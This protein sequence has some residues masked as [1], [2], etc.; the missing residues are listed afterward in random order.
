MDDINHEKTLAALER[1]ESE[2]ARRL[3]EKID[4]GEVVAREVRVVV[5][6]DEG[7][8]AAMT[9]AL[10]GN[11]ATAGI[12]DEFLYIVTNIPPKEHWKEQESSPPAAEAS[13]SSVGPCCPP[14]EEPAGS[15]GVSSP[16]PPSQPTYVRVIISNGE[17][18]DCGRI[19]EGKYIVEDG[20]VI[21]RDSNGKFITSRALLAGEDPAVL[22][23]ILLREAEEPK[24]F[25]RPIHYPPMGLA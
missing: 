15:G 25:Q 1:L 16:S 20:A 7:A 4:A 13:V 21:L 3:Q 17:D 10:E 9:R 6:P 22:A 2:K 23:R 24:D 19:A 5:V 18:G 11:P 8:E 12:H 14:S